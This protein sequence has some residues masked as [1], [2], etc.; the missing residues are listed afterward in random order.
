M[1]TRTFPFLGHQLLNRLVN[2]LFREGSKHHF[3]KCGLP[4]PSHR[5]EPFVKETFYPHCA[6]SIAVGGKDYIAFLPSASADF[7]YRFRRLYAYLFADPI[8][9][10][11]FCV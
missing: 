6:R 5:M 8:F 3:T 1:C 4:V 9:H 7:D 11:L 10:G 2:S